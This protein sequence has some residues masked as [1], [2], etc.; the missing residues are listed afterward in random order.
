MVAMSPVAWMEE[1]QPN[2]Q[3]HIAFV[4]HLRRR[5]QLVGSPPSLE[6]IVARRPMQKYSGLV[7]ALSH[8]G[9]HMMLQMEEPIGSAAFVEDTGHMTVDYKPVVYETIERTAQ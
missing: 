3:V 4:L 1:K 7:F 6:P 2:V 9:C 5:L 8:M